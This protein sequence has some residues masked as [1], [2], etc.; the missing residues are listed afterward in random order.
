MPL[1]GVTG[2]LLLRFLPFPRAHE[3]HAEEEAESRGRTTWAKL[4][5]LGLVMSCIAHLAFLT[6]VVIFAGG[7][8]FDPTPVNAITVDI[9]SPEEV[10]QPADEPPPTET[11]ATEAAMASPPT[12]PAAPTGVQTVMPS[13]PA[14]PQPTPVR[15]DPPATP[16]ALAAPGSMLPPP[17]FVVPQPPQAEPAQPDERGEPAEP[18]AS[19]FGMPLTMPDGTVGGRFS[20]QAVDRADITN[21]KVAAFRDHLKT[22]SILPAGVAPNVRVALRVHLNPDGTLAA[23]LPQNPEPI[24]V[25]GVSVGGGALFQS[26]VAALRKCQPYKMLPPERY[27]EWKALD[28]TF[29]PQN[30]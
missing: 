6:P 18:A 16:Q 15:P 19:L 26:A 25:E 30:F 10:P 3:E 22:C 14:A 23:G 4:L 2:R 17:P 21:D 24:R 5:P 29:T 27:Q 8:P 12:P 7:S 1:R 28:L 13:S 11:A 20:S 9:V